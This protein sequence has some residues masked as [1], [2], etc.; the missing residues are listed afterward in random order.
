[1]TRD[2][3]QVLG[4]CRFSYPSAPGAFSRVEGGDLA[5]IRAQLYAPERVALR[6]H[7]LEHLMLLLLIKLITNQLVAQRGTSS[8]KIEMD[9]SLNQLI[10]YVL[11]I[12]L[13][14]KNQ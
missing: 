13:M 8:M 14:E 6:L 5:A 10:H 4:Q 2:G 11:L 9:T 1:M 3:E 12:H 7:L